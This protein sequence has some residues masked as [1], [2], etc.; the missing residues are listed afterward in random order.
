MLPISLQFEENGS[1]LTIH[2]RP[3]I[4][5]YKQIQSDATP[6]ARATRWGFRCTKE[7]R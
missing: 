2:P 3:V 1:P 6:Y 7:M 5:L 4:T